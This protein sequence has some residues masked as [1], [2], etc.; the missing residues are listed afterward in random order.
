MM[1]AFGNDRVIDNL[2]TPR[3]RLRR[4]ER[5]DRPVFHRLNSDDT[6]MHFFP[7]RRTRAG[8]N[9]LME[10]VTERLDECGLGFLALVLRATDEV[11]GMLGLGVLG[12]H[13]PH[14]GAAEIGWRLLPE[15]WGAGYATE[16]GRACVDALFAQPGRDEVVSQCVVGN[17]ASA[18]VMLRLGMH[19]TERFD[20]PDVD[21]AT[22]RHLVRHRLFRLSRSEWRRLACGSP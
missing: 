6:I 22:H 1:P 14:A 13:H 21:P 9:A 12:P 11:I 16:G 7:Q 5:R 18:A 4:W 3:L 8:S 15:H 19:E 2:T 17:A 20:H 10:T